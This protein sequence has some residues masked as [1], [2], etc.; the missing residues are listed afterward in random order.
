MKGSI[1]RG[2]WALL[3]LCAGL[4]GVVLPG[5]AA[6][7]EYIHTDALGSPVAVTNSAG[8]VI[9]RREYEPYGKQTQPA[10]ANGPGY[11]GHVSD[12]TTGLDYMQQR[13]YDPAIGRFL[14]VDP[15]TANSSTGANFNRYWY[16]NNSPY[17]FKDPDG[18]SGCTGSHI[19]GS[20]FCAGGGSGI[21]RSPGIWHGGDGDSGRTG[22]RPQANQSAADQGVAQ[23]P[24]VNMMRVTLPGLGNSFLDSGMADR[25]DTWTQSA[26]GRGVDLSFNSAYRPQAAQNA[27]HTNPAA[28]TPATLSLHSAGFA[29]DVNY[30]SLRNIPGGL[31][32]DQQRVIIRDTATQAG[33]SWGGLFRPMDPPHFYSDPGGDRQ[34]LI[35]EAAHQVQQLE[36]GGH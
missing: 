36:T 21:G 28:I 14:S 27:L 8:V 13:Y 10:L 24:N 23:T 32:G 31:T 34:Q 30:S 9:E 16:A 33:L 12:A 4:V 18:R 17:K 19:S 3:L 26:A 22:V 15:V 29:V 2:L 5:R 7:V 1:L 25:V 20:A 35:D 11:T 6:T